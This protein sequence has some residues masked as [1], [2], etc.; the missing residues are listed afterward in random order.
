MKAR[1]FLFVGL[2][3]AAAAGIFA[4][5]SC[6]P[7]TCEG[8]I[9]FFGVDAGQGSMVSDTMWESTPMVGPWLPFERQSG[10]VF[11]IRALGGRTPADVS[12]FLSAAP[13]PNVPGPNAGNQTTGAGNIALVQNVG[14]NRVD[15]YN[16]T[17]SD[18]YVRV[19]V[20]VPPFPP[21]PD[22]GPVV[23][24]PPSDDDDA[25]VP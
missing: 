11:D 14:P 6:Y 13:E 22:G 20:H 17:C 25:G 8:Q 9:E 23:L 5:P 16:D 18:Y 2:W 1:L 21:A 19:V 24:D 15:V 7:R 12:V 10:Y 4:A 3:V